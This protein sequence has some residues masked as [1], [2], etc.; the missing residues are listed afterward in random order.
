M[1]RPVPEPSNTYKLSLQ[2]LQDGERWF[3]DVPNIAQ[4]L[5]HHSLALA[6]EVGEFCNI[7]KKIDRHSLDINDASTRYKLAMELTDAY[8]YILNLAGII[9]IDL[10]RSY[11]VKRTEN[12]KRFLDERENREMY[13]KLNKGETI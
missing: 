5:G 1:T 2:C 10:E 3:G 7:V 4:G 6:G 9:H 11:E 12:N 13:A 8:I